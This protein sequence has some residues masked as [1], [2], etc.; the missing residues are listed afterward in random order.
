MSDATQ[1]A[2]REDLAAVYTLLIDRIAERWG[3]VDALA[4]RREV[5]RIL[6]CVKARALGEAVERLVA[7]GVL[8]REGDAWVAASVLT[9]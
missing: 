9:W 3:R 1:A 5:R 6:G 7:D 8:V 4:L 2:R